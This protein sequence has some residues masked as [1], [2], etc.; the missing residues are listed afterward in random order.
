MNDIPELASSYRGRMLLKIEAYETKKAVLESKKIEDPKINKFI[1]DTYEAE[2]LYEIRAQIYSGIALPKQYKKY[3]AILSW[4]GKE[5][6]TKL[7]DC[8]NGKCD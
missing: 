5:V 6:E 3:S 7:V 8:F 1:C 4:C 2:T